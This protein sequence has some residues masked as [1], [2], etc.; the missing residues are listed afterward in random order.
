MLHIHHPLEGAREQAIHSFD[1]PAMQQLYGK[2]PIFIFDPDNQSNRPVVGVQ[3]NPIAF[4]QIYPQ[5]IRKL[6]TKAFTRGITDPENGRVRE[7]EWRNAMINLRDSIIYCSHCG[8]ENFYDGEV[9]KQ[10]GALN[11]CWHCHQEIFLPPR[12]KIGKK[13]IMLNYDTKLYPHH[14]DLQRQ[15]DFS[16][17][18]AEITQNPQ[19]PQIWGLKN[20]SNQDWTVTIEDNNIKTVASGKSVKITA[21]TKINFSTAQGEIRT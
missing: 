17:P 6:F 14:I 8:A 10:Q 2:E 15:Y 3:D 4:W 19:N 1:L 9:L 5:V 20:L 18:L 16:I 12:I 13:I 11:P 21:N 7:T